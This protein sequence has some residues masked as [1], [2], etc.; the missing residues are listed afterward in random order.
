M[1]NYIQKFANSLGKRKFINLT[2]IK[3]F[4]ISE[5]KKIY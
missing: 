2:V 3:Y 4:T 5:T 1:S